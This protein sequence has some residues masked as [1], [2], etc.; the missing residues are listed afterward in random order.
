MNLPAV[1]LIVALL[2]SAAVYAHASQEPRAIKVSASNI[3][4]QLAERK[5]KQPAITAKELAA[6]AN[7]LLEK[8]GFDYMFDVCDIL[9]KRNRKS[10]AAAVAANYQL[11]LTNG[12]K[13]NFKFTV[14]GGDSSG[15]CGECESLIPSVQVSKQEMTVIA[16]GKRHRARRPKSFILDEAE[17]VDAT[18]KKVLRTWQLPY[19]T[20]PV[21]ISADGAKLYLDLYTEYELDDLVLELS[22]N[23]RLAF[24]DRRESQ[25]IEGKLMEEHPNDPRNAYLSFMRFQT[26]DKTYIVRFSGPCT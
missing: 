1:F 11:S 26:G 21:G 17:L 8:R 23:G 22:E 19:Q 3:L 14:A 24:R 7:E 16:G 25:L 15:M 10:T 4:Q 12:E 6:Y 2:A 5:K 18:M 20:I 13:R 9:S